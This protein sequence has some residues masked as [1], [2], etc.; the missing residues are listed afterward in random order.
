[1]ADIHLVVGHENGDTEDVIQTA[2]LDI[3][4]ANQQADQSNKEQDMIHHRVVSVAIQDSTVLPYVAVY[5]WGGIVSRVSLS[6]DLQQLIDEMNKELFDNFDPD[7]DDARIFDSQ[8]NEVYSFDHE[9]M[10]AKL[11]E[12]DATPD[13]DEEG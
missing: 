7:T 8:G 4:S 13:G 12:L 2:W 1:M 9:A 5:Q 3:N 11:N 10:Y 6:V